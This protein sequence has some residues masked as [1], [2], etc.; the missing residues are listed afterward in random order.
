M[1][2]DS[3]TVLVFLGILVGAIGAHEL[4]ERLQKR[5]LF[6]SAA[7]YIVLGVVLGPVVVPSVNPF[8]N[9]TSVAPVF[10]FAAGWVGLLY[11]LE[12]DLR[13]PGLSR[14]LRLAIV[15]CLVTLALVSGASLWFFRSGL[16]LETVPWDIAAPCALV[17]GAAAS[18]GSSSAV[19]LLSERFHDAATHLLPLL[20][21]T[22]RFSSALAI[23]TFGLVFCIWRVSEGS[24]LD[25]PANGV[26]LTIG[27]GVVLGLLFSLFIGRDQSANKAFLS[28]VGILVFASGAAFFLQLSALAVNL[29]LGLVL[30]QTRRGGRMATQ[31]ER[32]QRPVTL[33]LLIFAGALW[34]PP[35]L[36]AVVALTAGFIVLRLL[37]K[38]IGVGL[39]TGGT[40]LRGDLWRGLLDQG[41]VA[42]AMSIGFQLVYSHPAVDLVHT[43]ILAAVVVHGLISPRLL[44]GLLV[45][46]GEVDNDPVMV[47]R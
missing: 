27:M 20:R 47:G 36:G 32:T 8:F 45:D 12:L 25:V 41:D 37:A 42:V 11:G 21:R 43:A 17:L 44:Q 33:T 7:E 2:T 22:T 13:A 23:L 38:V 29:I 6:L 31:L 30:A 39:A 1:Q 3:I 15:D 24:A 5:L 19:D 28:M 10:A 9:L 35:P 40:P 26:L 14:P 46:A 34:N 4:V 16:L 18:A